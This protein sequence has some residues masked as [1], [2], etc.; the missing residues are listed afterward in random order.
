VSPIEF[1]K[2]VGALILKCDVC[3]GHL[4]EERL[5][6][7]REEKNDGRALMNLDTNMVIRLKSYSTSKATGGHQ[8]DKIVSNIIT[9]Q[10]SWLENHF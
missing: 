7:G 1:L 9:I 4:V 2:L 6:R 10:S 3:C 8:K 5:T